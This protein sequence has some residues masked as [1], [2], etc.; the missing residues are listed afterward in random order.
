[1]A[2]AAAGCGGRAATH[3]TTPPPPRPARA[4]DGPALRGLVPTPLPHRPG[5]TLTDT[6]GRP[7]DFTERT[8]GKL[9]YLFFGYTHCPDA[10][11]TAMTDIA[12]AVH[13]QPASVRRRVAVVF[14]T[15]DPRRDTRHVLRTWLD[16]YD[17]AFVGLTG[18]EAQV[19]A[20]ERAA[21][22]PIA[23][24]AAHAGAHYAVS[25]SSFVLPYSPDG[26]AHVVY[27]Q[28]FRPADY[29]HDLPLLLR[30]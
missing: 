28:G 2:L 10:C 18:S 17:R 22:I 16:H 20:A 26:R 3:S 19:V 7:Y 6:S 14:V 8:R 13:S 23:P 9:T 1:M 4:A 24:R 27:A 12:Y 15:V 25:H 5:F 30:Y 29:A 11:P 21:G